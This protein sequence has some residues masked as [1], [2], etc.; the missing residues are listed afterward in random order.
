[1]KPV[2]V[3]LITR[4]PD[5]V[6]ILAAASQP[7]IALGV[8]TDAQLEDLC[9]ALI[10][11]RVEDHQPHRILV[12]DEY[13]DTKTPHPALLLAMA[14]SALE[15]WDDCADY[16]EWAN[17]LGLPAGDRRFL[18]LSRELDDAARKLDPALRAL[19]PPSDHEWSLNCDSAQALRDIAAGS[20]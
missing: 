11:L 4:Y 13:G 16:L 12:D 17:E 1:M 20:F 2:S 19:R 7:R 18:D 8:S 3:L 6:R 15:H 14:L 9:V 10:E 5:A